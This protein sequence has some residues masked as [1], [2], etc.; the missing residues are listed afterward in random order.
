ML[1]PQVIVGANDVPIRTGEEDLA[2]VLYPSATVK[3]GLE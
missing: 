3:K 1:G 2:S